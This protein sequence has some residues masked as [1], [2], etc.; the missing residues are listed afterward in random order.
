MKR[1]PIALTFLSILASL[2]CLPLLVRAE[3]SPPGVGLGRVSVNRWNDT[4]QDNVYG[5]TFDT[6]HG[7]DTTTEGE[8]NEEGGHWSLG[9]TTTQG[10]PDLAVVIGP[11]G[12]EH[13]DPLLLQG[14]VHT[15]AGTPWNGLTV[16]LFRDVDGDGKFGSWGDYPPMSRK[17]TAGDGDYFFGN[18]HFGGAPAVGIVIYL[19]TNTSGIQGDVWGNHE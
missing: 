11:I 16:D 18:I 2:V 15:A 6:P 13:G 14:R 5:N 12:S 3:A 4:S 9:A 7:S 19:G 8:H 17:V 10:Q 1:T